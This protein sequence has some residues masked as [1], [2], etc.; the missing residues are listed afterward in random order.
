MLIVVSLCEL[1]SL[2]K[3]APRDGAAGSAT[4]L[5]TDMNM[6]DRLFSPG[7]PMYTTAILPSAYAAVHGAAAIGL[8]L[9]SHAKNNIGDHITVS[10]A[11]SFLQAQGINLVKGWIGNKPLPKPIRLLDRF[12]RFRNWAAAM[13]ANLDSSMQPFSHIYECSDGEKLAIF[14]NKKHPPHLLRAMGLW[15]TACEKLDISKADFAKGMKLNI[16]KNKGLVKMLKTAFA[17][18][19]AVYW[20][21]NIGGIVPAAKLR[22]SD[23]WFATSLARDL[24]LRTNLIDPLAGSVG[25]PGPLVYVDG[26][27]TIQPRTIVPEAEELIQNW[28]SNK[29]FTLMTKGGG[30]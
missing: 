6:Y 20:D 2:T 17:K 25:V 28:K 14:C 27:S 24:G 23:E 18:E 12:N 30:V 22:S 3:H 21:E 16:R 8:T 29:S 15:E 1:D 11:G 7:R 26:Y 4:G 9:L 19:S 13:V 5:F 10:L